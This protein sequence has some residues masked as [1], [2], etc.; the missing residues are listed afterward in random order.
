M[1]PAGDAE[2]LIAARAALLDALDALTAQR[3]ALVLIGGATI[4]VA[5]P[6]A[7]LVAKLH[8]LGERRDDPGRLLD[9]DAHDI[10]ALLVAASTDVLADR[11]DML[12]S[13][14][15][16]GPRPRSPSITCATCSRDR[17]ASAP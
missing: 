10:C 14:E 12:R 15:L 5:G 9:K 8:K 4:N 6:A 16:A 17:T 13:D 1:S 3:D 11:L 2:L 7:L